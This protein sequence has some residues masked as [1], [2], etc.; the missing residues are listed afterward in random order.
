[1]MNE[2]TAG[3]PS[4]PRTVAEIVVKQI[5]F[6]S[7]EVWVMP[8]EFS[9]SQHNSWSRSKIAVQQMYF[10]FVCRWTSCSFAC[11]KRVK[12]LYG[13]CD[14]RCLIDWLKVTGFGS[15]MWHFQ[16]SNFANDCHWPRKTVETHCY[17]FNF[18]TCV[19][20]R[21]TTLTWVVAVRLKNSNQAA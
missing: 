13:K 3:L 9:E 7:K 19:L 15:E 11:Y 16:D 4:F 1:M 14:P 20:E 18:Q 2:N 10:L 6:V 5:L 8:E 21:T 12:T 17:H